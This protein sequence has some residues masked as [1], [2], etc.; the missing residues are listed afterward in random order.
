M[1]KKTL[2]IIAVALAVLAFG[3]TG[4]NYFT[5]PP[6]NP[7]PTALVA[8]PTAPTEVASEDNTVAIGTDTE[9]IPAETIKKPLVI[10]ERFKP[11]LEQNDDVVGWITMPNTKIDY[12]VA[13]SNDNDYYLHRNLDKKKYEPG[14]VFMDFRNDTLFEDRYSV[15]YGHNMKDGS[16][17]ATLKYYKK[18]D[19]YNKNRIFAY[20]TLYGETKWEIFAAYV[21]PPTL[22]LI[23]TD[24]KDDQAFLDYIASRQKESKYPA[25]IEILA[26]DKILTLITCSYEFHDARFVVHARL[27]P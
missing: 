2:L 3:I 16:M 21:S 5:S 20:S 14:T 24:F 8:T 27:I 12:P 25:D 23:T 18:E 13:Q 17:F 9:A 26:T 15:L 4:F 11:L 22:D 10:L 1:N 7:V 19:F 6:D